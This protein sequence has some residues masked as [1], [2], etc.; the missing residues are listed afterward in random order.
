MVEPTL[1]VK[2]R[3]FQALFS[4]EGL[5][6]LDDDFLGYL[7]HADELLHG[8]LLSYRQ[9]GPF[10]PIQISELI[11][12]CA[13][14]LE[15]FIAELF[16]IE[17]A[18]GRLQG[19]TLR[20]DPVFAFKKYYVLRLARRVLKKSEKSLKF[21]D[22]NQWLNDRLE[23]NG[24]SVDG[25]REWAVATFGQQL[26][27]E[28]KANQAD[29]DQLAAWC[30]AA[31]T[32]EEGQKLVKG[33]VSFHLPEH[34]NYANLVKTVPVSDDNIGRLEGPRGT[35]RYR[36][37]FRLTDPRMNERQALDH[38]HYCV[39]CHKTDG[40]FCSKG[41][42]VKKG[43]K[44]Q[45]TKINPLGDT[46]TGC[47]LDEKI[48]EMHV[49][50]KN[51]YGI[52]ALATVMIDNPMCP[53]TGHRIC[54]DCMKGCIYQKQEPVNIPQ[55][56]TRVLMDIL[57]LPWGVEVYDLLTRWNP[58]RPDQYLIKPYNGKKV[59]VM[60][61]GPAG[62]TLAHHLLMEGFAVVGTEGLKIE[63][64]PQALVDNPIYRYEDLKEHLDDRVMSGFGG[65]AEYG[66]T[67]RWDKN[68]L[69]LIY[70]SLIRRSFFQVFGSVRFGGTLKVEDA[71]ILGFD[72]LSVAVGAGLPR[73]IHVPHSMAPGMRQANDFLMALQLTGA[74]KP[75]SLA[76]LQVRL[77]AVV[78]GGGLTGVDTATEVQAYYITQVEKISKRYQLLVSHFGEKALRDNF[79][80]H[81]LEILDE[82]LSHADLVSA[83]RELAIEE[84]RQPDFIKLIRDWGGVTIA[85]RRTMQESPAYR[86]NHEEL[87]KALEEGIY[88]AEGL[89]PVSL[90]LDEVGD[91]AALRCQ[92]RVMDEEG[93]WMATDEEQTLPARSVFVATGAKPNIAY[94][95]E[96]RDTFLRD[97]SNYERFNLINNELKKT[98]AVGDVKM[99]DFGPFTSYDRDDHRVSF[100]GDTHPIFHGSVVKAIASAKRAY[101]KIVASLIKNNERGDLAEYQKFRQQLAGLFRAEVLSVRR[102][103][104]D[105]VELKVRAPMAVRNFDPGQFYRLQNYESLSSIVAG[106]RLQTE[107][108][109]M[110]GATHSDEADVLSFMIL[111]RGASSRL[112]ATLKA[113]QL[114][115]LMGPTGCRSKIPE[116]GGKTVMIIGGSMASAH[117]RSL[118]PALRAKGHRVFYVALMESA[119]ELH[120]QEILQEASDVILWVAEK[121]EALIPGRPQDL[122]TTGELISVLRDY[123]LGTLSSKVHSSIRLDEVDQV[124]V[125]GASEL[126]RRVQQART[127]FLKDYFRQDVEFVASVYGPMQCMLKGV[128]AQCLQWQIDPKTGERT[129]AV[130][131]CSWQHQPMENVDIGNIDERLAQNRVQEILTDLWLDYLFETH[132]VERV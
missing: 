96:H 63:P 9:E 109:A 94:A 119:A 54:N 108:M 126:L 78:I 34:L 64:L 26:L 44:K 82:F 85:Y 48:S 75:S 27:R 28:P 47:P 2:G 120:S 100:L 110:V 24:L 98:D 88:Y 8:Q 65:V 127:G 83:E 50:K 22:L 60:G 59:L 87:S 123:A 37:G 43:D 1:K 71:W 20:H 77:P 121:G 84:K 16:D 69:K 81:P 86:R 31:L 116:E 38:I 52:A 19:A 23:E 13:P 117:L 129:K 74:A 106:T 25:D 95:F 4:A 42:P 105:M 112:V 51:G 61:M 11:I 7:Q 46:L 58:L 73:E 114:V 45:G 124:I 93:V 35:W 67:V 36:D 115:S 70:I 103:A 41:F 122:A 56:E 10:S 76:N 132:Q 111:E 113:G 5:K 128:C 62:F 118:G 29:I 91:A 6:Q 15:A 49:L 131:A 99:K 89:E 92:W 17:D 90:E 3:A 79:D 72:H 30:V 68:F 101:P 55:V 40:D 12:Q 130:Y 107:A 32:Q 53:A 18:V 80:A 104:P 33:W 66:I 97:G 57:E 125:V 14:I 21:Y 39:Y 102:H